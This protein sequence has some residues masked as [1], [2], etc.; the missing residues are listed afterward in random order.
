MHGIQR[1]P[2]E[3]ILEIMS[4]LRLL[5]KFTSSTPANESSDKDE[6]R[7]K[8]NIVRKHALWS[9]CLASQ[10]FSRIATSVLY[11]CFVLDLSTR[12]D[13]CP[14][15]LL[16]KT[17]VI[18]PEL[19]RCLSYMENR[20]ED[21]VAARD[22]PHFSAWRVSAQRHATL[23]HSEAAKIWGTDFPNEENSWAKRFEDRPDEAEFAL[24]IALAPNLK[25]LYLAS[26]ESFPPSIWDFVGFEA[27]TGLNS[28]RPRPFPR[29]KHLCI[30][31]E[32]RESWVSGG[33]W[34]TQLAGYLPHLPALQYLHTNGLFCKDSTL[35]LAQRSLSVQKIYLSNCNLDLHQ[36]CDLVRACRMLKHFA[37]HYRSVDFGPNEFQLEHL[38]EALLK[39]QSSLESLYLDIR[40]V[41]IQHSV[42]GRIHPLG[43]LHD[44]TNLKD[45][46][47][48]TTSLFGD[49]QDYDE[50]EAY[51][52]RVYWNRDR[53]TFH[54]HNSLPQNLERLTIIPEVIVY[55][56]TIFPLL[57][58][59]EQ[60]LGEFIALR[61]VRVALTD[62]RAL[63]R[64]R[65]RFE[66][67]GIEFTT[68]NTEYMP[69]FV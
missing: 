40:Q 52:R 69:C 18:R 27:R 50:M 33:R 45:L 67:K 30:D 1:L 48:C 63:E 62:T 57:E 32:E 35:L 10:R 38:K 5:P 15:S 17:L 26:L 36:I 53:P 68:I 20:I 65:I 25:H 42:I 37:C 66:T 56:S 58:A 60:T 12:P 39:H 9:L 64:I 41:A 22:D 8:E 59:I 2:D 55:P 23:L 28:A 4:H 44:F 49:Q 13:K 46:T 29:L 11:S 34:F 54:V 19:A 24:L 47:L 21:A 14:T 31:L 6:E 7:Y 3:L 43:I 61:D 16:L 51:E